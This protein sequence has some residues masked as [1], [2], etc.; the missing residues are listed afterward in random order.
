[1]IFTAHNEEKYIVEKLENCL[2]LD[3]PGD[4]L[5]ILAGLDGCTDRTAALAGSFHQRGLRLFISEQ[6]IGKSKMCE[7]LIAESK[8]P[9]L[10]FT[11][12]NTMLERR[13]LRELVKPFEDSSVGAVTGCLQYKPDRHDG[14]IGEG[15]FKIFDNHLKH[16]ESGL[17][18]SVIVEGSLYA[19]RRELFENVPAGT[20]E[21]LVLAMR[22]VKKG[23]RVL[24]WKSAVSTERFTPNLKDEFRRKVRIANR[25]LAGLSAHPECLNPFRFGY[26]A[27]FLWAH[28]VLPFAVIFFLG[29]LLLA[30]IKLQQGSDF[31][32]LVLI[33][34]M[35]FYGLAM[36][37]GILGKRASRSLLGK[38]SYL[39]FFFCFFN[40]ALLVGLWQW[41][42]G[43]KI[44][45]WEP[46]R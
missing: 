29:A 20:P 25:T 32:R 7:R 28:R 14:P 38:L 5:E 21:D 30:T 40:A 24:Y 11:D 36:G 46:C 23:K 26:Y 17:H 18:S 35:V 45:V 33:N 43:E 1:M 41:L 13:T 37:Y 12:A 10:I 6:W 9:I 27:F 31:W 8:S 44:G 16:W 42:K 4:K 19:V 2:S 34:Q 39:T 15:M 22:L 3:Y